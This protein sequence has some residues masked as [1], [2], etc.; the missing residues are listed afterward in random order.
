MRSYFLLDFIRI[1]ALFISVS[2]LLFGNIHF[3]WPIECTNFP[4]EERLH[5]LHTFFFKIVRF[6]KLCILNANRGIYSRKEIKDSNHAYIC[7][8][9]TTMR[10]QFIQT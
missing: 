6:S 8:F 7:E 10:N 2:S 1:I 5:T 4:P 9:H 3:L